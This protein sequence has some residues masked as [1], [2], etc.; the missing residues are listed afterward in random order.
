MQKG[1]R[2]KRAKPAS[3]AGADS[4]RSKERGRSGDREATPRVPEEAG[5]EAQGG[6]DRPGAPEG[7]DSE[8]AAPADEDILE[9]LTFR[10]AGEEYAVDILKVEEIIRM[11]QITGIPR[12]PVRIQ[13]IISLRGTIVPLLDLRRRMAIPETP[14]T[15]KTR[16][17]VLNLER[18]LL[19]FIA[20]EVVEVLKTTND[21]IESSPSLSG[22]G[23]VDH[24]R[25]VFRKD[26]RMIILLDI[27]K[28]AGLE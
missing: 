3:A 15:R 28:A 19:G 8:A 12:G 22:Q 25:G 11:A 18:G 16:M 9:L 2:T 23:S 10:L 7:R 13:G 26:K 21:D 17:I 4:D 5:A 6:S 24:I 14:E 27:E 20:D 1:K